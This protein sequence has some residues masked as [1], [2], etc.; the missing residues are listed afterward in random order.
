MLTVY[1]L[2]HLHN[3]DDD[4]DG[5]FLKTLMFISYFLQNKTLIFIYLFKKIYFFKT[6]LIMILIMYV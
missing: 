2:G 6:V 3:D 5:Y 1:V 4:D